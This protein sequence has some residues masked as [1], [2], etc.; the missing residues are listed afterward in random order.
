MLNLLTITNLTR[1]INIAPLHIIREHLEME[2]LYY[3]SQSPLAKQ[4]LFYGGTAIR[5]A[6]HG[7][8]FSEDLDFLFSTPPTAQTAQLLRRVLKNVV[9][10]NSGVTLEEVINK[11]WTLFGLLHITH[12][13]LKHPIRIKIEICK[14]KEAAEVKNFLLTSKTNNKE[15]IFKTATVE[16]L[17]L[18][19]EKAMF[20]RAV[21]RDWFDYWYL[22]QKLQRNKTIKLPFPFPKLAFANDLK[23]WL[24]RQTWPVIPTII[25]FYE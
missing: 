10:N 16:A 11:R 24:P 18:L 13:L 12:E 20:N 8:R 25:A 3:L 1:E 15:I 4:I 21:P 7:L 5:L 19:K 14:K 6:H 9:Q 23:R 17:C 22:C 2:T